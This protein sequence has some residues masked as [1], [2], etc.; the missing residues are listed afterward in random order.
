MLSRSAKAR[1]FQILS[2]IRLARVCWFCNAAPVAQVLTDPGLWLRYH[3]KI[4]LT[5]RKHTGF[6]LFS[7]LPQRYTRR[8]QIAERPP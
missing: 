1:Y 7:P 8:N 4:A 6:A 3:D 5:P 2:A